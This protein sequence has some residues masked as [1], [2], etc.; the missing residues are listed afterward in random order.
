V[1]QAGETPQDLS[2]NPGE[3]VAGATAGR[4]PGINSDDATKRQTVSPE[5][6]IVTGYRASLGSAQ[7]IKRNSDAILDAVVA[8]D[9]GKLPDN[10]AAESLARVSGV[11]AIRF[12]DEVRDVLVRGLPNVIT[13][14]NGRDI[15]T[16]EQRRTNIQDFPAGMLAGLE[17]YKSGSADLLEPGLAGLINVRTQKP[18]DFKKFTIAGGIR[19]SYNDQSRKYD[20]QANLLVTDRADTAIGEIGYLINASYA[21]AQYRNA[22]RWASGYI[23]TPSSAQVITPTS[24]GRSFSY[25]ERVA[26][27][28]DTG[29]RW[30][31][32]VNASVQ[33][34]PANN[35]EIYYDFLFQGFRG[36]LLSD[37]SE[38]SL[39]AFDPTLSNV[40]LLDGKPDQVRSFLKSGGERGQMYRSTSREDTNGYQSAGGA[41]WTIGR[42]KLSTDLAYTRSKF[43]ASAWSFDTAM[44]TPT[45]VDVDFFKDKGVSFSLPGFDATNPANYKWRGYYESLYIAKGAGWQWRTDLDLETGLDL[46]PKLQV[47]YRWTNRTSSQDFG[48]RYANTEKLNIPLT[49]TPTGQLSMIQDSFRGDV[50]SWRTWLM[51]S[52]DGIAGNVAALRALARTSLAQLV[53]A[54]PTDSGYADALRAFS[55]NNV[56]IN[57]AGSNYG[58]ENTYAG[59]MQGKYAFQV[60]TVQMDGLIGVRIVN[61]VGN[62]TGNSTVNFNGSSNLVPITRRSNYVD[63]LP[64]ISMR[65]HATDNFQIR[66][67]VT[68]TRT[69]PDF[70]QLNPSLNITQNTSPIDPNAPGLRPN[71]TGRVGNPDLMPL[72]SKN[73]DASFEWYMSQNSS[74]TLAVFY[75]D[76][77]GFIGDYPRLVQDPQ[78]GLLQITRPEN[79]GDGNIKGAEVNAQTFFDFLPGWLSGFGVQGN[80]TYVDGKTRLPSSV[81]GTD[82]PLVPITGLS[83]WAYNA[84]FFY[85]KGDLSTRLSYNGRSKYVDYYGQSSAGGGFTGREVRAITRLDFSLNYTVVKEL[86]LTF[87]ATNLLAQPFSNYAAYSPNR[88]YPRDLRDEGRY[89]GIGARFRF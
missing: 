66:L 3:D 15:F 16:A 85:E 36:N 43:V 67:G 54:N 78:Y 44:T 84:A 32:S 13:T 55:T 76:L 29:R 4:N 80:V 77:F 7:A 1:Q 35:L 49:A 18:F 81:V 71:A 39:R 37:Q 50:Q 51:P 12:A 30:R 60:G 75:R 64:N 10:T 56:Q 28:N 45:T 6:I 14:F 9:I 42:A 86:T 25:P 68:K 63:I 61:T 2:T 34:K 26:T 38:F 87:D 72:T 11:Q 62:Y 57:P 59:Y 82:T 19:G 33:W 88:I 24:A 58:K 17:V 53:A 5:D 22:N 52:R 69:R 20:P 41:I 83:K 48:N 79:A 70:S 89:Y 23:V 73:Y 74:L 46:L 21:Q 8:Q 31:P 47:G 65:I 40:V 27:N